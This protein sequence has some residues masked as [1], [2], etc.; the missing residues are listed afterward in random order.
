[1][2]EIASPINLEEEKFYIIKGLKED[3]AVEMQLKNSKD[4]QDLKEKRKIF[5]TYKK[6][7]FQL[8]IDQNL[9][10]Q[11]IR[12]K[13]YLPIRPNLPTDHNTEDGELIKINNQWVTHDAMYT[14]LS[15]QH[16]I[17]ITHPLLLS[18]RPCIRETNGSRKNDQGNCNQI[19]QISIPV[20]QSQ[21]T[22]L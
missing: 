16:L 9:Y 17:I 2:K 1:M 7:K 10:I 22:I 13:E 21:K 4:I 3:R 15:F 8:Q 6:I 18:G 14:I 20:K 12:R 11:N 5:W 19:L